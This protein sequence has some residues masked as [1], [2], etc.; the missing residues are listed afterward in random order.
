MLTF[1]HKHQRKYFMTEVK[2][3]NKEIFRL[4]YLSQSRKE[5]IFTQ[6][7][8]DILASKA[9][10]SETPQMHIIMGF[11]GSGK[12]SQA[13]TYGEDV[14]RLGKDDMM[15]YHPNLFELNKLAPVRLNSKNPDCYDAAMV[16]NEDGEKESLVESFAEEA[17]FV[18]LDFCQSQGYNIVVDGLPSEEMLDIADDAKE[19]GY[20]VDFL[21]PIMPKRLLELNIATRYE[22]GQEQFD[23]ALSGKR[24]QNSRHIPHP[25]AKM[26]LAP[27]F[28]REAGDVVKLAEKAGYPLKVM[29]SL[30]NEVLNKD[31]PS[32]VAWIEE[33]SRSINDSEE[34]YFNDRMKV[35]LERQ[36]NRKA[37]KYDRAV[38][39]ALERN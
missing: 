5:K 3:I 6:I 8:K 2:D 30:S 21:V 36:E 32:A 11:P 33:L 19:Q 31:K 23:E 28:I 4:S 39:S 24:P 25:Y 22:R 1:I 13:M 7:I 38:V 14:V 20:Q 37:S 15:E 27:E 16:E 18:A 12:T 35:L 17:F 26:R 9:N 34:K 10:P 29:N